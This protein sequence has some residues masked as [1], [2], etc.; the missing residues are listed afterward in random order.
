MGIVVKIVFIQIMC[1][2]H[3]VVVTM[4]KKSGLMV[5][6]MSFG[7]QFVNFENKLI[8]EIVLFKVK[9]N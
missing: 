9:V 7:N 3:V 8:E 5:I 1:V 4:V 6:V 2:R